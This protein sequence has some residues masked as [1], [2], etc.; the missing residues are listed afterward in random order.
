[1]ISTALK[2]REVAEEEC[3]EAK[4][5]GRQAA[6]VIRESPDVFTPS[7]TGIHL[8]QD[9]MEQTDYVEL[10]MPYAANWSLRVSLT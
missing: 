1:M 5:D 7:L 6:L 10:A 9:A 2:Q 8:G 3:T 4:R